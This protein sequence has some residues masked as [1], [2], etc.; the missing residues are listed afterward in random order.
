MKSNQYG[1]SLI[2]YGPSAELAGNPWYVLLI[3]HNLIREY[4]KV[5]V[6]KLFN[7]CFFEVEGTPSV[8]FD[9]FFQR[10]FWG[11]TDYDIKVTIPKLID[12]R[13]QNLY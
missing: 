6:S 8:L 7:I 12:E 2:S 1:E 4:H 11:I 13:Y 5:Q 10:H 3:K 9:K